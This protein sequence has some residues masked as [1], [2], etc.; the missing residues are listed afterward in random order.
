MPSHVG[1]YQYTTAK[2]GVLGLM[3][4]MKSYTPEINARI[5]MVAP[6][7]T[8]T[9]ALAPTSLFCEPPRH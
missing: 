4:T 5:N 8:R 2:Y 3:R 6:Y 9:D 1:G 7:L